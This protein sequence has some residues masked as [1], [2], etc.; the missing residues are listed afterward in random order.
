MPR[1]ASVQPLLVLLH[2]L[3]KLIERLDDD[4]YRVP[5]P[6]RTSGGVGGH[7]RH[8]LDHVSALLA[9]TQTGV[10]AYDRRARGT[11]VEHSRAAAVAAI[12]SLSGELCGLGADALARPVDVETQVDEDGTTFVA[13]SSVCR[14]LAFVMSHTVHHNAIIGQLLGARGV[15]PGA[16]FGLAPST[17]SDSAA[18]TCAR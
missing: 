4:T 6:G 9:S 11:E 1:T 12:Q 3:R 18:A 17:P 10:C 2:Q 13:P 14:E 16:R 5:A 15:E 7:V 8:C